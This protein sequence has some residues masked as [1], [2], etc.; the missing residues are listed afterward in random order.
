MTR[1]RK[2]MLEELECRLVELGL[3]I[4]NDTLRL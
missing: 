4:R 3:A 2:I 1:L